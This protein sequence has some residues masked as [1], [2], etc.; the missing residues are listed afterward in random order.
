MECGDFLEFQDALQKMRQIDDK[1]IYLLNTTIPTESFKAQV[2][3]TAR[4]KDLFH[5]IQTGHSQREIAIKKCLNTT[6]D[7]V[8]KLKDQKDNNPDDISLLK[9]LRKEQNN[10]RMLESE[11]SVEE[12]VKSRTSKVY[13]EK[14]RGFYK[15]NE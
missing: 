10:L 7:R 4:C 9:T 8:K 3:A 13:H 5:Q 15:P 11:L 1:I 2:D 12:V 6:R 14:C